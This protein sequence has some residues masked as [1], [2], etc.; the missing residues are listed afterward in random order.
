MVGQSIASFNI[1][2]IS[3]YLARQQACVSDVTSSS[4]NC[5]SRHP[6]FARVPVCYGTRGRSIMGQGLRLSLGIHGFA[7]KMAPAGG[8]CSLGLGGGP[9]RRRQ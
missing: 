1:V 3:S 7:L 6:Q 9:A 4:E 2:Q 8:Y 5:G